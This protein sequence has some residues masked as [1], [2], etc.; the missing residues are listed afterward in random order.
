MNSCIQDAPH[1]A[2]LSRETLELTGNELVRLIDAQSIV[3]S[4][5]AGTAWITQQGDRD[6]VVI[7][8]GESFVIERP[9]LVLVAPIR[10]ATVVIA[11]LP[12]LARTCR[13][14]R[15]DADGRHYP[16][17]CARPRPAVADGLRLSPAF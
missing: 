4:V 10:E 11:A 14:T 2:H 7:G 17:L 9:G 5:R 16:V 6:D 15:I 8:A 1:G 3:V 13:I 12:A